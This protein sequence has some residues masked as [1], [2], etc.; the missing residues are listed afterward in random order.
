MQGKPYKAISR[1]FSR[2]F[3]G[4]KGVAQRIH[5]AERIKISN[6]EFSTLEGYHSELKEGS[7]GS[8]ISRS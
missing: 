1:F 2:N 5:S 4:Q 3:I 7:R 6:Q 8:Q